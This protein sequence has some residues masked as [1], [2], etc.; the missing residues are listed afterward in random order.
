ML[1]ME[2]KPLVFNVQQ[3]F[4]AAHNWI[5]HDIPARRCYVFEVLRYVR[6]RLCSVARLERVILDSKDASLIVALR[7]VLKDLITNKGCLVPLHEQPRL[8]AKK[9][10]LVIGGS[11]REPS[12]DSWGRAAESTYETIEKYD[13]FTG[14]DPF[15]VLLEQMQS[16]YFF[17]NS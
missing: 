3:V 6:L 12:A 9:N 11:K 8:C 17:F 10:I 16:I 2:T 5:V 4:Q 15:I 14:Y 7:S 13:T 1:V